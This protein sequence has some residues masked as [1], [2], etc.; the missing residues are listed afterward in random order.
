MIF[1]FDDIESAKKALVE[2]GYN[3]LKKIEIIG[4]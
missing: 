4:E 1:R 3:I 2:E